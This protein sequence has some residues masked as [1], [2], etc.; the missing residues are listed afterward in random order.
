MK[1]RSTEDHLVRLE[2]KI[3]KAFA[4]SQHHVSIFFDIEKA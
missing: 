1:S 4:N 2:T 3:R